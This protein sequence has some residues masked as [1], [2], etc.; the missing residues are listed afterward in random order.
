MI[1]EHQKIAAI[2][3]KAIKDNGGLMTNIQI[4]EKGL[5]II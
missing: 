3:L 1:K 2:F 4:G 5:T